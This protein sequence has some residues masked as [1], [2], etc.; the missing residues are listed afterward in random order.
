MMAEEGREGERE[1]DLIGRRMKTARESSCVSHAHTSSFP[2][3]FLSIH[4]LFKQP[5]RGSIPVTLGVPEVVMGE[6]LFSSDVRDHTESSYFEAI[7]VRT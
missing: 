6:S 4:T 7:Q 2:P 5:R 3:S 1:R